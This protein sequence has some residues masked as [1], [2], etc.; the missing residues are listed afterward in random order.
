IFRLF[1]S[2]SWNLDDST[3]GKDNEINPAILGYIFE[4]YIN[5]KE[6]GAYY[7]RNE[8]TEYLCD[9]TIN[10]LILNAV[11]VGWVEER[12]PTSNQTTPN[13][14]DIIANLDANTTRRLL[15][16][17]LPKLTL[18]DPAC[19][20][21]AFLVAA[22]KTLKYIYSA[23]LGKIEYLP[24]NTLTAELEKIKKNHPSLDYF[25][26]KQIITQNLYGVDIM[27]EAT[28][29]AKL[30]LFLALVSCAEKV[31]ELEPLPNIDFNIMAGNSL[32]G[33]MQVQETDYNGRHIQ[34]DLFT[35]TYRQVLEEKNRLIESYRQATA[36][37]DDLQKL[38]DDIATI[39]AESLPILDEILRD[40][41][42]RLNIK[43]EQAQLTGKAQKREV[44]PEDIQALE[45]FHWGYE[46]DEIIQ[47]RGGF[48][49]IITN[50]PWEVLQTDEKE[51]F[52]K[53]DG[54]IQKKKLDIKAWEQ[55]RLQ[56]LKDPEIAATWLAYCSGFPHV[57]AYFKKSEQYK[58][59]RSEISG[60]SVARKINLYCLFVEQCFNLLRPGGECGI[61]IPSGIYTDLGAKQL[62]EMLFS[63]TQVTGLFGFENR[64]EIFEGVHRSFKFVVLTFQKGGK[65][66][67]FPAEF[68]RHD[69]ADL[70]KFPSSESLSISVELV[71]RLSPDS[72]SV[73]EF[74]GELDIHI[75]EKMAR[76]PLLGEQIPGKWN[77]KL[78]Q[79]LNMTNDSHL[80][81]QSPGGGRLALYEGKMIHQFTHEYAKPRYWIEEQEGRQALL[82][83]KGTDEGQLLDY[84]AY[85]L[86]FR[87]VARNTDI[88]T[89]IA[90]ILPPN[91]LAGNTL[92]VS[93][94]GLAGSELILVVS[95][96]NSFV[97][98]FIIRQKVTAHCNMFY[99]YQTPVP[100]LSAGDEY[101]AD[102]LSRAAKLICTTP[103]C[104]DLAKSV[105]IGSH[106]NGV[107]DA[108]S[109]AKL[110]AELDGIIAHLYGLN[111]SEF[112]HILGNFPIVDEDAKDKAL[113]EFRRWG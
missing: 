54:L 85:R 58:H 33:L 67:Q 39:K 12:N 103:E 76:F 47:R 34:L 95:M 45:P 107:T 48:D 87:D 88:R 74:K 62:R 68:M 99:I 110:R 40:E 64:Q 59:Q 51:F 92:I 63:K 73:M 30:R 96:L 94:D 77:L 3:G 16:E 72:I 78:A 42:K 97:C 82:G 55:Q 113:A 21:G 29:I 44:T 80:F 79:E 37:S 18:L 9:R 84:Q 36:Y 109:R 11:S 104:D 5:Q 23:L 32:I 71:R 52:Q 69:V 102:I 106:K 75:A 101:C 28:E 111:E 86:G 19:G 46:F 41:F 26:T 31:E 90:T 83:R 65:T 13:I 43:Y 15:L 61:V 35:K 14:N 24:D 91:V 50:P 100:R 7:T 10:Q 49:A 27:A 22:M 108:A 20:S 17:T 57:S 60:K 2:Y 1:E 6:F 56:M 66:H 53:Y 98:D 70:S 81:H 105:G 8:I 25:I 112:S 89:M 4:K 93:S 38:R